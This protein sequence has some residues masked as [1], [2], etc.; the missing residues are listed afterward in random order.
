MP[1]ELLRLADICVPNETEL[2]ALTGR[3]VA[4]REDA[5][6]AARVVLGRGPRII[7]VTLGADGALIV[8]GHGVAHVPAMPVVAVDT[9]GAGD[10]FIG[11]LAVLSASGLPL[12][13]AV[14]KANALAALSVTRAG[15]QASFATR[16]EARRLLADSG[17]V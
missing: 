17:N 10:A 7:V 3:S 12:A 2:E 5:V 8:D 14:R 1:D 11:S 16:E 13:D 6:G 15:T 4:S 9:A